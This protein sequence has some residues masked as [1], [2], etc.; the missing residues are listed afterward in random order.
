MAQWES[1]E[2]VATF[3]L[4][5]F[6][7]EFKL[8]RV[9]GKQKVAGQRSGTNWEIDA[10][11]VRQGDDGFLIIECRR[12]TT[13]KQNQEKVGALAYRILDTGAEG[14]IIVSPLGLQ[15]GAKRV[16]DAENIVSVQLDENSTRRSYVLR[17][18]NQ[19]MFGSSE[20]IGVGVSF[21]MTVCDPQGNVISRQ[22]LK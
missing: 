9:E 10:K 13:S 15:E 3:L 11:G 8:G 12:Y 21:S 14:G 4:N 20:T 18:L 19:V 17:F 7:S 5:Q 6:A 2:E 16:A 22:E 1:Y